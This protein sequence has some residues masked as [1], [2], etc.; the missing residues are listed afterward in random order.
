MRLHGV[1]ILY[2]N[3]GLHIRLAKASSHQQKV[4]IRAQYV[5]FA[6][7]Q[8]SAQ[9]LNVDFIIAH[10]GQGYGLL[11]SIEEHNF[12]LLL[13][14]EWFFT[15]Q[16]SQHLFSE[17]NFTSGLMY[18]EHALTREI[19]LSDIVVCPSEWQKQ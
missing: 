12:K 8:L 13:Y 6:I 15:A 5:S 2:F 7:D 10:G 14:V 3:E 18:N 11:P 9:G 16:L 1:D 19:A 17:Y 4:F